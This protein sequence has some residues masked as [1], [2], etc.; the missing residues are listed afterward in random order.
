MLEEFELSLKTMT[1]ML[2]D[3]DVAA[4]R[5]ILE[6]AQLAKVKQDGRLPSPAVAQVAKSRRRR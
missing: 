6:Q 3:N 1:D 2:R 5:M 4:M